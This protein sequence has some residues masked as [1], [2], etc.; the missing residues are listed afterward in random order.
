MKFCEEEIDWG[1]ITGTISD[2]YDKFSRIKEVDVMQGIAI[3]QEIKDGLDIIT[4][5]IATI[6]MQGLICVALENIDIDKYIEDVETKATDLFSEFD[7]LDST[8]SNLDPS[9]YDSLDDIESLLSGYID[10]FDNVKT[11]IENDVDS[12]LFEM[13][14]PLTELGASEQNIKDALENV[15]YLD[16]IRDYITDVFLEIARQSLENQ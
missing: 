3:A 15:V 6:S 9:D 12:I 2:I 8:I 16:S 13:F 7:S 10:S 5:Q 14:K 1:T 4:D 11:N